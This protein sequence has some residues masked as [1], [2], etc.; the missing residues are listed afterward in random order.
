M[1]KNKSDYL[2]YRRLDKLAL[3]IPE[4]KKFPMPFF[5]DVWKFQIAL[6]KAEYAVNCKKGIVYLPYRIIRK[7]R[8]HRLS[9]KYGFTI[10]LN[11]FDAGLSIAHY[12]TIAVNSA[13]KVGKFCRIQEGVNIGASGGDKSPQIGDYVFLGTGAKVMGDIKI[14]DHVAVGAGAVVTRSCEENSVTLAG[15][16]AKKISDNNSDIFICSAVFESE[17]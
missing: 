4:S 7:L 10:P 8:F 17:K 5:D 2:E 3:G 6:R 12:G 11:V 15:V 16:P 1:I 14:G 13:A 9:V